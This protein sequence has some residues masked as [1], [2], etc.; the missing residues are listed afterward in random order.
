MFCLWLSCL[1]FRR[2]FWCGF[3]H[4]SVRPSRLRRLV[5][6]LIA[7]GA[8]LS[9]HS[10]RQFS[11]YRVSRRGRCRASA[12]LQCCW[13]Q[14]VPHTGHTQVYHRALHF[15]PLWR[16]CAL[17]GHLWC[18]PSG[19]LHCLQHWLL[20]GRSEKAHDCTHNAR[21]DNPFRGTGNH[22]KQRVCVCRGEIWISA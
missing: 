8:Q 11:T 15:G 6:L 19:R 5:A 1:P 16:S 22:N 4:R 17:C 3:G 14:V 12:L 7:K 2:L 9:L 13:P 10:R 18:H 20:H 21:T